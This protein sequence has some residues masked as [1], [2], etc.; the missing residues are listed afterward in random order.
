MKKSNVFINAISYVIGSFFIQG[1]RFLTLPF[2]SR[3]MSASDYALMSSYEAW[4]SVITIVVGVQASATI[5]NAYIDYG[6][7]KIKSYVSHIAGIGI[8]SA[9]IVALCTLLGNRLFT[10]MFELDIVYLLLGVLQCLFSYYLTVLI[11]TYRIL[12]KAA[13]YLA[14]SIINSVISIGVGMLLV[15]VMPNDK[16]VGRIYASLIAA[17]L[18]GGTACFIIYRDG[19][20][21]YD[22]AHI[23]YAM[24]LSVPLVFHSLGGVILSKVDQIMLLKMVGQSTMGVY[25]YGTNFAHIIY[26]LA[27]ACNLAYSPFYYTLK[28]QNNLEKIVK[29]NKVYI[30]LYLMGVSAVVLILPEIIRIMSGKAY[31]GAIYT[32]PILAVSFMVNFLYTFLVNHEFYYKNTKY[33]AYATAA[34]AVCNTV[35]NFLLVPQFGDMGAAMATLI[36]TVFQLAAHYFIAVKIVRHY[37]MP[38]QIFLYGLLEI[39]V[40]TGVYYLF[41]EQMM[42]RIIVTVLLLAFCVHCVWKN[43]NILK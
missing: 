11:T 29:I 9:G 16:Y 24:H 1:L 34:S 3:I 5:N 22:R 23:K 7:K 32:A 13:S 30:K 15:W 41:V 14:F 37:E 40:L 18:I 42:I 10:Q 2:F 33:I 8:V 21:L 12:D 27:N 28:S 4:I 35:L 38:L 43:R 6:E 17:V 31:Y 19:K 20:S 39:A 36:S 26:V 25:S